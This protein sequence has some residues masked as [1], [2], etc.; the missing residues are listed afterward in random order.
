[1]ASTEFRFA[2]ADGLRIACARW[3]SRGPVRAVV[4]IVREHDHAQG[5]PRHRQRP[6][7]IGREQTL[8]CSPPAASVASTTVA[9]VT[10]AAF[11]RSRLLE[12]AAASGEAVARLLQLFGTISA[13]TVLARGAREAGGFPPPPAAASAPGRAA[14]W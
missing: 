13:E 1:M 4:Q 10:E 12:V 8:H 11:A 14:G 7:I 5:Q 3:D 6:R 9:R 2:S